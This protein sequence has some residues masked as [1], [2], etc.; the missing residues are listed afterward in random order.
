MKTINCLIHNLYLNDAA[1]YFIYY[2]HE[3]LIDL[4]FISL[5]ERFIQ[6]NL[7]IKILEWAGKSYE[8]HFRRY[9]K[10]TSIQPL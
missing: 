5:Q 1:F 7:E 6:K 2:G 4:F 10:S 8:A 3:L 9:I